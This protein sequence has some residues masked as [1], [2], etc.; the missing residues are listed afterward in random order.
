MGGM[1]TAMIGKSQ[2]HRP[3]LRR[4]LASFAAC[5]M[6]QRLRLVPPLKH[7]IE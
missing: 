2:G 5:F 1:G 7:V 3:S 4:V 6:W